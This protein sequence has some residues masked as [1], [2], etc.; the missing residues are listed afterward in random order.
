MYFKGRIVKILLYTL[1]LSVKDTNYNKVLF[2]H[3][4][5]KLPNVYTILSLN[6][7]FTSEFVQSMVWWKQLVTAEG[8]V[9]CQLREVTCAQKM[10][11]CGL[12]FFFFFAYISIKMWKCVVGNCRRRESKNKILD[13]VIKIV[14]LSVDIRVHIKKGN[15]VAVNL[16]HFDGLI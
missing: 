9:L 6:F 13:L 3:I 7:N 5:Y 1:R 14:Q 12:F 11:P 2:S 8:F 4:F 15:W 10:I 16:E